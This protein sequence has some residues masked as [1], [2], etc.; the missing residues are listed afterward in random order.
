MDTIRTHGLDFEKI[1]K[2]SEII[3]DDAA[4]EKR[5]LMVKEPEEWEDR[6]V[7]N[8]VQSLSLIHI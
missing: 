1:T 3:G 6:Y 8:W 2:M 7:Y 5:G 4:I